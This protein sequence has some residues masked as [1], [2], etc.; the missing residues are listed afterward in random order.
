[1]KLAVSGRFCYVRSHNNY[2]PLNIYYSNNNF[3]EAI[4][5]MPCV[6][7]PTYVRMLKILYVLYYTVPSSVVDTSPLR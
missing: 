5:V 1:M 2:K 7:V 6:A 4:F 3:Y